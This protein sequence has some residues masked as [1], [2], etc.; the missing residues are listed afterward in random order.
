MK[1]GPVPLE[2]AGG[3]ILAHSLRLADGR[4]GKGTVLDAQA[5]ARLR[6]A[7]LSSVTVA[8]LEAGDLGEDE[9]ATRVAAHVAGTGVRVEAPATGRVNLFAAHGGLLSIDAAGVDALNLIDPAITLA[10]LDNRRPVVEGEMVATVKIIPYAVAAAKVE[11]AVAAAGRLVSV[12]PWRGR[13]VGV[14]QTRVEGT[15][16]KMLDKTARVLAARLE[17][18]GSTIA[19]EWRVAHEAGAVAGAIAE[20]R[21]AGAEM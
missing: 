14:V 9:A 6:A 7:G 10:T 16:D 19:G 8:R 4:L 17:A 5:L 1:F 20:A 12:R 21:K 11:A 2:E 15:L 3:A 13:P 18:S